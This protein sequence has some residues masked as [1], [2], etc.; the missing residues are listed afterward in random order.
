[1]NQEVCQHTSLF[2]VYR[3]DGVLLHFVKGNGTVFYAGKIDLVEIDATDCT[4][5]HRAVVDHPVCHIGCR[6]PLCRTRYVDRGGVRR[7]F[8]PDG[9]VKIV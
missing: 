8:N 2:N 5:V 1:M 4:V 7:I 3:D 6:S 9:N